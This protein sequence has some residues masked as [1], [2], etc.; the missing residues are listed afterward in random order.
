MDLPHE[1]WS[2]IVSYSKK[3]PL[4]LLKEINSL[5]ELEKAK[6]II[7]NKI[8]VAEFDVAKKYNKFDILYDDKDYWIITEVPNSKLCKI[9]KVIKTDISG[10]FGKFNIIEE[11]EF[12]IIRAVFNTNNSTINTTNF[13]T[14]TKQNYNYYSTSSENILQVRQHI[15]DLEK[16]R[17]NYSNSLKTGDTFRYNYLSTADYRQAHYFNFIGTAT[18]H[19]R[20]A[21]V[22][23]TTDKYIYVNGRVRIDKRFIIEQ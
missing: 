22:Y 1:L 14:I 4:E 20:T 12:N 8:L 23:Y 9:R 6:E 16:V 15:K 13:Y 19:I 21:K 17:I 10:V 3:S 18:V 11:N 5:D 2:E 7:Q